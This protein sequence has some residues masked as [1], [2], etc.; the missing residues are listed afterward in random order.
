MASGPLTARLGSK[1][2]MITGFIL[3]GAGATLLALA[4]AAASLALIVAG[5]VLIG[6]CS[7]A[8]PAMT[9]VAV[10]S[11]GREHAGLASAILNTAR[12]SGGAFGIALLGAL[13]ASSQH[14][15]HSMVLH[16]PLAVVAAGYLAAIAL[17]LSIRTEP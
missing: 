2:P 17:T 14:S 9:A 15:G 1:P 4:N 13:L 6:L 16:L 10:G 3:A 5:S 12:Q 8:M 11:A 7:L